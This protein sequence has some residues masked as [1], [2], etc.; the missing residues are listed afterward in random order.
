MTAEREQSDWL[1]IGTALLRD[2]FHRLPNNGRVWP[3][4]WDDVPPATEVLLLALRLAEAPY[5]QEIELAIDEWVETG[6]WRPL[7][8][9]AIPFLRVRWQ[10]AVYFFMEHVLPESQAC[11]TIFPFSA[12]PP[13]QVVRWVLVDWWQELGSRRACE[14]IIRER[15]D[16]A[17]KPP[18]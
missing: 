11:R 4:Y 2:F 7:S 9:E 8:D 12:L 18:Q 13:R 6:L 16:A 10:P 1:R 5:V 14:I 17:A 3:R 15:M